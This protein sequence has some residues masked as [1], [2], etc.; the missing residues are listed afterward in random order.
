M[1][2]LPSR[3]EFYPV[4]TAI[5]EIQTAITEKNSIETNMYIATPETI[6]PNAEQQIV[7]ESTENLS[8]VD[9]SERR[10]QTIRNN[11]AT[12]SGEM[13]TLKDFRNIVTPEEIE[14]EMAR[15]N[16]NMARTFLNVEQSEARIKNTFASRMCRAKVRIAKRKM[17]EYLRRKN[18]NI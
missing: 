16:P 11:T 15:Y 3:E 4:R 14:E 1:Q 17:E 18:C 13:R 10:N 5:D 12:K 8:L 7:M 6:Q 2:N 9:S